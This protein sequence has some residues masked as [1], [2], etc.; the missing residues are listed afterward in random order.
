ME[1]PQEDE[2]ELKKLLALKHLE[3]GGKLT[4]DDKHE[5]FFEFMKDRKHLFRQKIP[6]DGSGLVDAISSTVAKKI[7]SANVI[8]LDTLVDK[9]EK[10][11]YDGPLEITPV[12]NMK[13]PSEDSWAFCLGD[14]VVVDLPKGEFKFLQQQT[15]GWAKKLGNVHG[16]YGY[17]TRVENNYDCKIQV[18]F[19]EILTS[20]MVYSGVLRKTEKVFHDVR[21]RW[22]AGDFVRTKKNKELIKKFQKRLPDIPEKHIGKQGKVIAITSAGI[23]VT[24]NGTSSYAV[25]PSGLHKVDCPEPIPVKTVT[26]HP[27]GLRVGMEVKVIGDLTKLIE[28]QKDVGGWNWKM[29]S[30]AGQVVR[31]SNI[32]KDGS[33]I[34]GMKVGRPWRLNYES[35][36]HD[37]NYHFDLPNGLPFLPGD[38]VRLIL[39]GNIRTHLISARVLESCIDFLKLPGQV[40]GI[41]DDLD[42]VVRFC[43]GKKLILN[44]SLLQKVSPLQ[45]ERF[46]V[47]KA[48]KMSLQAESRVKITPGPTRYIRDILSK[49][50]VEQS[51]REAILFDAELL[52]Y[53]DDEHAVIRYD[54]KRTIRINKK[55]LYPADE[56]QYDS[57]RKVDFDDLKSI[58]EVIK[59]CIAAANVQG[60]DEMDG[61]VDIYSVLTGLPPTVCLR[62]NSTTATPQMVINNLMDISGWEI[63]RGNEN[64]C[65]IKMDGDMEI[66]IVLLSHVEEKTA[67]EITNLEDVINDG[68]SRETKKPPVQKES[69]KKSESA[70]DRI[71]GFSVHDAGVATNDAPTT[72]GFEDFKFLIFHTAGGSLYLPFV[73]HTVRTTMDNSYST[74]AQARQS[75]VTNINIISQEPYGRVNINKNN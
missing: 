67:E 13:A 74:D 31:I 49:M 58:V 68:T 48:R 75:N 65:C 38:V 30:L 63:T 40:Q 50:K 18:Y 72:R 21:S 42:V 29:S 16:Q 69:S 4:E 11:Q 43:N 66:D 15:L 61:S 37:Y 34:V 33:L 6:A 45:A 51:T 5:I 60:E 53:V 32:K 22:K 19:P 52:G 44:P 47:N 7:H 59:S 27:A 10:G 23:F 57:P 25:N 17:V 35:V 36:Y 71:A 14:K 2:D 3:R 39:T 24:F 9:V 8:I 41:D 62:I 1:L 55:F 54:D 20:T 73:P 26:N 46:K 12:L 28:N 70:S 56:A 64:E